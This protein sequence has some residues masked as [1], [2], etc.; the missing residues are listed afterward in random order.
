MTNFT[1]AHEATA[2][3][4]NLAAPNGELTV[5]R[6]FASANPDMFSKRLTAGGQAIQV[7][8]YAPSTALG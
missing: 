3:V 2:G 1:L 6:D 4:F 7:T 8:S 5:L